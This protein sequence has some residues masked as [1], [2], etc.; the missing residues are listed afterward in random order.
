MIG[1]TGNQGQAGHELPLA[2]P[3]DTK[4]GIDEEVRSAAGATSGLPAR[5]H[6]REPVRR[7]RYVTARRV[8]LGL[9]LLVALVLPARA[10]GLTAKELA[11]GAVYGGLYTH[12]THQWLDNNI[13]W[14]DFRVVRLESAY[15]TDFFGHAFAT[16]E[17]GSLLGYVTQWAGAGGSRGRNLGA[18]A[19]AFGVLTYF[20]VLNGFVPGIRLDPLD[21]VANAAGAWLATHDTRRFSLQL[22]YRDWGRALSVGQSLE[23]AW[24]DYPNMRFGVGY[25]LGPAR[26]PWATALATYGVTSW[27]LA[28]MRNEVGVAIELHPINWAA[29]WLDDFG[30]GRAVLD[31]HNW[32]D[33]K[34]MVPGLTLQLF[35]AS[36]GPLSGRE[37][38]R[39]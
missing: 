15:L 16:R 17:L 31:A 39:E 18:W 13:D 5:H 32:L 11:A 14:A 33:R 23:R 26:R 8:A 7:H 1:G 28:D 35:T 36:T 24:H 34:L 4:G 20:E 9:L 29:T 38:F 27:R 6:V 12:G 25:D 2:A 3:L 22:G 37:P 30:A 10:G 19:G 21:P